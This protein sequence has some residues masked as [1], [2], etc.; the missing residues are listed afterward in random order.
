MVVTAEDD[1][2]A[3][4]SRSLCRSRIDSV[5]QIEFVEGD[6]S[7]DWLL[8]GMTAAVF[9]YSSP[10]LEPEL[11]T[12]VERRL[13]P[14]RTGLRQRLMFRKTQLERG[15]TWYEYGMFIREKFRVPL[16]IVFGAVA[17]HNHF[18]LDRGKK[19]CKQSA[20]VIKLPRDTSDDEHRTLV[21]ILNSSTTCFWMKQVMF[22]KSGQRAVG[23]H[24]DRPEEVHFDFNATA[25]MQFPVPDPTTTAV[26]RR[27]ASELDSLASRLKSARPESIL[28]G[29][30][31]FSQESLRRE[32]S[33]GHSTHTAIH[34]RMIA[35]QEE[36]DWE[37]YRVFGLSEK[38]ACEA[39]LSDETRG[40]PPSA[41]PYLWE[42]ND[43]PDAVPSAWREPYVARRQLLNSINELALIEMPVYK[44]PWWGR[45][46]VYGRLARDY[47]GWTAE[48]LLQWLL[49]RLESYLDFDGRMNDEGKPT[50]KLDIGITSVARLADIAK[51][52]ADFLQVGEVY[53]DDDAFDIQ[54]L[55][56]ELVDAESVPH[57]PVLRYKERG[58][59]KR[60]E[61]ERTWEL[62]REEDELTR[63]RA[64]ARA[65]IDKERARIWDSLMPLRAEVDALKHQLMEACLAVRDRHASE[66]TFPPDSDGATMVEMLGN[67]GVN[68]DGG[69]ALDVL[70]KLRKQLWEKESDVQ[71]ARDAKCADDPLYQAAQS[72]LAAIPPDPPIDVPPK[73]ESKD[74]QK[75]D[76]WRLRGK[77]DVPKERWVSFPHCEGPDGTLPIAWAGYDHLQLAK[78]IGD[79]YTKVQ[80]ELGGSDDP[81]LIP[82]LACLIELLPWLK[83]WHNDP[84]PT[85]DGMRMGDFFEGIIAEECRQLG[86]TIAEIKAWTPPQRSARR[87][88][89][90]AE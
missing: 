88:R 28:R 22:A 64:A 75:S 84:D 43:A 6:T 10:G 3:A 23:A 63:Q 15:L 41:R 81:R 73:Y 8:Q 24:R 45:Q 11:S 74:F 50:A 85:H 16:T 65:T 37:V 59:R 1:A 33:E 29:R 14:L 39:I 60:A 25:L 20:P 12:A 13:W 52:D 34:R 69:P 47:E 79:Y 87:R 56:A 44:R 82:L 51:Q 48:V 76:Y 71:S 58:L 78:A 17:T 40:I 38:G 4:D 67:R 80:T 9:P 86:K 55:V 46:G 36:L 89:L 70:A 19:V 61:W 66:V 2:F 90:R 62:Q 21:G 49:D 35:L 18:V 32:L 30:T 72:E 42:S 83:Q 7:R 77:L 5:H 27:I 53:R 54:A 68:V 26:V 57:L 31:V